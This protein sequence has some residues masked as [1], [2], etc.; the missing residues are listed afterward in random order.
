LRLYGVDPENARRDEAVCQQAP[1]KTG[2][3]HMKSEETAP[4]SNLPAQFP[5]AIN[6][7]AT[8]LTTRM[9][10]NRGDVS[11]SLFQDIDKKRLAYGFIGL[12][13]DFMYPL[14]RPGSF[15]QIDRQQNRVLPTLWRTEFDRPI[16][17][18]ETRDRF[19]CGWC[20]SMQ[21][22]L[23]LLPHPFSKA[24]VRRYR[25]P[26]EIEIVGRVIGVAMRIDQNNASSIQT[27]SGS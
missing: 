11:V 4:N 1:R 23:L 16:Y 19:I 20:E 27:E 18:V 8:S 10:G 25:Y 2:L 13:D 15:V 21:H 5:A 9:V 14:V 7:E 26:G 17:F 22:D 3:Y 12:E 24:S 6:L